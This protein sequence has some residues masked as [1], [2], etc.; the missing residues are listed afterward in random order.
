MGGGWR[1]EGRKEGEMGRGGEGGTAPARTLA[2]QSEEAKD[3]L[4]DGV[5]DG[6]H[7]ERVGVGFGSGVK[8]E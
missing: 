1:E 7:S 3:S 6:V 4:V 2:A 8:R 5:V